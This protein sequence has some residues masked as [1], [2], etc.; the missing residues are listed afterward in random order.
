MRLAFSDEVSQYRYVNSE[1]ER[2]PRGL[3]DSLHE[4]DDMYYT[5]RYLFQ[6][7]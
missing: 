3:P 5:Y 4:V 6:S 2:E 1:R 7:H